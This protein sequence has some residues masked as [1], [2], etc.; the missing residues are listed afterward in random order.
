MSDFY[1]YVGEKLIRYP[2]VSLSISLEKAVQQLAIEKLNVRDIGKL[3]DR[4]EGQ[5]FLDNHLL[6][7]GA[8]MAVLKFLSIKLPKISSDLLNLDMNVNFESKKLLIVA[9]KAGNLPIIKESDLDKSVIIVIQSKPMNFSIAGIAP[10][11]LLVSKEGLKP[12]G[13]AKFNFSAFDK[14]EPLNN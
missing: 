7:I 14:L 13:I 1:R 12:A 6:K 11:E 4:F 9:C 5:A 10:R 3:R 8:Y 2:K